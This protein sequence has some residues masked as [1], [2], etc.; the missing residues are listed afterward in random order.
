[1]EILGFSDNDCFQAF[2]GVFAIKFSELASIALH[3][4][5]RRRI[6][7]FLV[8]ANVHRVCFDAFNMSK[9]RLLIKTIVLHIS[10]GQ[11]SLAN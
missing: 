5:N 10:I 3:V 6:L 9:Y 4:R 7:L 2:V 8:H 11:T 1:M